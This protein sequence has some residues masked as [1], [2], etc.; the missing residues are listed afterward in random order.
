MCPPIKTSRSYKAEGEGT[1]ARE[2]PLIVSYRSNR[3]Y[4]YYGNNSL[5]SKIKTKK[6]PIL[7]NE[8][9]CNGADK[10]IYTY[11]NIHVGSACAVTASHEEAKSSQNEARVG[12]EQRLR[13]KTQPT[14]LMAWV[15]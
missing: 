3:S 4:S 13:P 1:T 10:K 15:Q 7:T 5:Y 6:P 11:M 14:P 9:F 2:N 8:R 12:T